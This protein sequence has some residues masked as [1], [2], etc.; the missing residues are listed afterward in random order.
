MGAVKAAAAAMDTIATYDG[1]FETSTA[2]NAFTAA[3]REIR[4]C[5]IKYKAYRSHPTFECPYFADWSP[6][7][8]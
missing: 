1:D 3:E 5:F 6:S 7:G 2:A 4:E 8:T